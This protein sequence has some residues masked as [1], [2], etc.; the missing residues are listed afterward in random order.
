MVISMGKRG[1]TKHLKRIA[2]SPKI[3]IHNR[4]ATVWL[5]KGLPGGHK[6]NNSLP[7]LVLIRE[8]LGLAKNAREAKKIL[9]DRCVQVDAKVR[10]DPKFSIGLM[11]VVAFPKTE[12]FYRIG[13]DAKGRLALAD[14]SKEEA[15]RKIAKVL[16]KHA[17]KSK[18]AI[19]LHDGKNIITNS[20]VKVGDSV[21]VA[22]PEN[23][24]ESTL[25]LEKGARC[26]ITEGKHAGTIAKLEEIIERKGG[27][28]AEARLSAPFGEFITVA[29]Y[30]LVV[31]ENFE[32]LNE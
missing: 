13:I 7:L 27:R 25:K 1:G 2:S 17:Y 18:I 3:P 16:G 5:S 4:K 6:K 12:M 19:H 14:I 9:S 28:R 10:T 26:L 8:V 31:D 24:L 22:L 30:V 21:I 32:G 20:D 15:K 11:D 23:K 29:D